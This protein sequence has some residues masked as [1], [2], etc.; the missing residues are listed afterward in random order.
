MRVGDGWGSLIG[1]SA[2]R[3]RGGG[4]SKWKYILRSI[5]IYIWAFVLYKSSVHHQSQDS[6]PIQADAV[7]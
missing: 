1:V 6:D 2:G 3:W 7:M 5:Y 4:N